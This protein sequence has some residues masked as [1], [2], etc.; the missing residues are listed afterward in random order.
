[1]LAPAGPDGVASLDA[2]LEESCPLCRE[3]LHQAAIG[4]LAVAGCP[5][6]R[7]LLIETEIFLA[8][9]EELRRLSL[10]SHFPA[11]LPRDPARRIDCPRCGTTMD[12]HPYA[13]PGAIWIDNCPAC[14]VNWLDAGELQRVAQAPRETWRSQYAE[15]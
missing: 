13:G 11:P 10:E 15:L 5:R 14:S 12:A 2:A 8:A 6:C 7:G 9:T 3:P 4:R 1:V